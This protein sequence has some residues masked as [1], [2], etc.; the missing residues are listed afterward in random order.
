MVSL[1][2]IR[3][4]LACLL[5]KHARAYNPYK[6]FCAGLQFGLSQ[7]ANLKTVQKGISLAHKYA[8]GNYSV[9]INNI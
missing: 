6:H 8:N 9:C 2:T 4:A 1:N 7:V 3:V 5:S